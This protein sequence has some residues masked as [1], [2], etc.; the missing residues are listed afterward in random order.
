MDSGLSPFQQRAF[1]YSPFSFWRDQTAEISTAVLNELTASQESGSLESRGNTVR[2]WF[3]KLDWDSNYFQCP[4][5]RLDFVEWDSQI[6]DPRSEIAKLILDLKQELIEKY[7]RFYLFSEVPSEDKLVLQALGQAGMRL[8]ETRLTYYRGQLDQLPPEN[9][10]RVRKAVEADI[11]H[12][13][14]VA[15]IA[16][17]DFD[18][19]HADPFFSSETADE[20]LAEYVEQC[21]R[22]LTDVVLVPDIDMNPPG[23]FICGSANIGSVNGNTLG[24]LVLTAVDESRRGGYKKLNHS[25][26][27]WMGQQGVSC[28]VN[29]TQST[30]RAVIHVSESLGYKY[31]RSTHLFAVDG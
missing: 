23:A 29:T 26:L 7:Q 13:R 4:T 19:F 9:G 5:V 28:I 20:F 11:P 25:L 18:R 16:R 15:K 12:L 8:V 17:N 31:G 24:R 22:G 30:N 2:I 6:Q 14:Q 1:F 10:F 21:V 3:K 27:Q